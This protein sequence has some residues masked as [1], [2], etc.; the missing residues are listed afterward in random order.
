MNDKLKEILGTELSDQVIQKLGDVELGI[1]N[2]GTLVP[3]GKHDTLKTELAQAKSELDLTKSEF[4]E[5]NSKI[6]ELSKNANATDESKVQLEE[7][8]NKYKTYEADT[9]KRINNIQKKHAIEK[10]LRDANANPDILDML[11]DKF[12]LDGIQLDNENNIVDWNTHL[13]PVR[14]KRASLFGEVK[15][16]GDT[17]KLLQTNTTTKETLVNQYNQAELARDP[18]RMRMIQEQ[19]K[20]LESFKK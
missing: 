15:L 4:T 14:E 1:V 5:M 16:Q 9:E 7:M 20:Q 17:P 11:V 10:G 19:I 3:A 13:E 6:E 18:M 12:D 2:D 8:N